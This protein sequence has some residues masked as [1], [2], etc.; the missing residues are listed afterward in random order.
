MKDNGSR[1]REIDG[2]KRLQ[3][4]ETEDVP[5]YRSYGVKRKVNPIARFFSMLFMRG[6]SL[7]IILLEFAVLTLVTVAFAVYAGVLIGT[8]MFIIAF[9]IFFFHN[10]KLPR[11]R[12]SFLRK[13][14]KMVWML[15]KIR[16]LPL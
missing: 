14:K 9:L 8:V 15:R 1:L 13:L 12:L 5:L 11:K 16:P 2:D 6:V 10:T 3:S 4:V 7:L